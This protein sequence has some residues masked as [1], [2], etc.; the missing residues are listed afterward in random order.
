MYTVLSGI[1]RR[2][3]AGSNWIEEDFAS[4]RILDVVSMY[5]KVYFKV[6]STDWNEASRVVTLGTLIPRIKNYD[7][8]VQQ[9]FDSQGNETIPSIVGEAKV[10]EK[11][12]KMADAVQAGYSMQRV[13]MTQHPDTPTT[14]YEAQDLA[15]RKA[16]VDPRDFRKHCLVSINGLIHLDDA[17]DETIYVMDA[18]KTSMH[19][20]R[21]EVGIIN[22]KDIGE[23]TKIRI[24][25]D[26]VHRRL[27]DQPMMH[28]LYIQVPNAPLGKTAMLVMGGYLHVMDSVT[29]FRVAD[30]IFCV[31]IQ[32]CKM[33][34]RYLESRKI[35]N[36]EG[37]FDYELY[38]EHD[39]QFIKEQLLSDENLIRYLSMSQ[40][41]IVF[42]DSENIRTNRERLVTGRSF[43]QYVAGERPRSPL[44]LGFGL[45]P[46]YWVRY[47]DLR[48]SITV[49]DNIRNNLLLHTTEE[50]SVPNPADNRIPYDRE[51]ISPANLWHIF[52][53]TLVIVQP[54]VAPTSLV[55]LT[56]V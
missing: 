30:N 50:D 27:P 20:R 42:I 55:S 46:P 28:Q 2:N 1:G 23:L 31:D 13:L 52:S 4:K 6:S 38:G 22:F 44:V 9:V 3:V 11:Y 33:I 34:D 15:M 36:F 43:G 51:E 19:S 45:L 8:T 5:D 24:T 16:D 17:D 54:Y 10:E 14:P 25:A 26:M 47:D 41:F 32:N 53:E 21:N 37:I 12:V 35:L 56:S 29:F 39:A 49:A 48:W 7:H 18:Q 40:S